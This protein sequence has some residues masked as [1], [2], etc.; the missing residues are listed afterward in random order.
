MLWI[1]ADVL[2]AASSGFSQQFEIADYNIF[3]HRFQHVVNCQA[4]HA[5]PRERFHLNA[6]TRAAGSSGCDRDGAVRVIEL[7]GYLD[8]IQPDRMTQRN[9]L[10]CSLGRLDTGQLGHG[11]D[12]PFGSLIVT[13]QCK[14]C[15]IEMHGNCGRR[16]ATGGLFI[17]DVNHAGFAVIVGMAQFVQPIPP[18]L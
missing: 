13:N 1:L 16:R 9:Q 12:V 5:A 14:R 17:G 4:G 6:G 8:M 10:R 7:E 2:T 18:S 3:L 15:R 11:E